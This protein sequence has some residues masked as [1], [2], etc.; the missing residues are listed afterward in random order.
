MRGP[1]AQLGIVAVLLIG[2]ALLS[3]MLIRQLDPSFESNGEALWWAF[4]HV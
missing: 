3:G 2:I 1:L 4:E